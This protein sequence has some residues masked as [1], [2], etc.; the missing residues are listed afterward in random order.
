MMMMMNS[1]MQMKAA[2]VLRP[3]PLRE[4]PQ[5]LEEVQGLREDDDSDSSSECR[6]SLTP[7]HGT[8]TWRTSGTSSRTSCGRKRDVR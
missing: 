7:S 2:L 8:A 4:V 6:R 3:L 1:M 5:T